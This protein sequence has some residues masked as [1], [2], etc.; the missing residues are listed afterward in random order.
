M[1][2]IFLENTGSTCQHEISQA[3]SSYPQKQPL[4]VKSLSLKE[5]C[6]EHLQQKIQTQKLSASNNPRRLRKTSG[7]GG[8]LAE[9]EETNQNH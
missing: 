2:K 4:P 1:K 8:L 3:S 9:S 7:K 5:R 6:W